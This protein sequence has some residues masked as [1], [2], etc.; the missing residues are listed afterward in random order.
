MKNAPMALTIVRRQEATAPMTGSV[1]ILFEGL[2]VWEGRSARGSRYLYIHPSVRPFAM[3]HGEELLVAAVAG[4]A[5]EELSHSSFLFL[6][7]AHTHGHR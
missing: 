4:D 5:A 7:L 1:C 2:D 3:T 6:S